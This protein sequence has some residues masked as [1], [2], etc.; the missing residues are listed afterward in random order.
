MITRIFT[1]GGVTLAAL[2]GAGLTFGQDKAA[3]KA[4]EEQLAAKELHSS[5]AMYVLRG[6]DEVKK[7][8]DAAEARL[9]DYKISAARE[10]GALK[11]SMDRRA[12]AAELTKQRDALKK[13]MDEQ[14]PVLQAQIQQLQQQHNALQLQSNQ[15]SGGG[16]SRM[17]RM[18][19]YQFQGPLNQ[20]NMQIQAL[21]GQSKQY[22]A[23][24][25][26]LGNQ[27]KQ[28]TATPGSAADP[29]AK[30]DDPTGA[31]SAAPAYGK[32]D[33]T[34][35]ERKEAYVKALGALRT[36]VDAT[37]EKYA[38]LADDAEVKDA[39]AT[40]STR[41][42]RITYVLGPSKR[43]LDTVKALEEAEARVASNT[44]I[45]DPKPADSAAKRKAK[46]A[47]RK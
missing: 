44:I 47:K 29:K 20:L 28:L 42:A 21:Q 36:A 34:S 18:A 1:T 9:K 14:M 16:R 10:R 39:L 23:T 25:N 12:M 43:F 40:L 33:L 30:A 22:T 4:A 5:G 31:G 3:D 19:N 26:E 8:S 7:A 38:G 41:S 27:I 45:E 13:E 2:I 32:P 37:K 11:A 15:M 24:Y 6:E 35:E 17:G 46:T